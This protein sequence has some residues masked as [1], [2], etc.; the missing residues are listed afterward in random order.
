MC[1][2]DR[3]M[4]AHV[5]QLVRGCFYQLR[6]IKTI[7]RFIPTSTAVIFVNSFIVSSQLD[8]CN[9]ILAGLPTCQLERIQSV[10][11]SAARLIY[12]RTPSDHVT[13]LLRDNLHWL[14]VPQRITYTLCLITYKARN[15]MMPDYISDFC[16]KAADNRL[17][18]KVADN[19][20]R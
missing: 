15:N 9:S 20:L 14:R 7:R 10:L 18:I 4:T 1:I 13:D 11:N 12:R 17:R 19:R 6:R 5:S 16:I 2:R 8:Y 3:T